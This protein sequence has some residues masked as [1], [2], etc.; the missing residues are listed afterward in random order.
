MSI[1]NHFGITNLCFSKKKNVH[2]FYVYNWVVFMDALNVVCETSFFMETG[3]FSLVDYYISTP[4]ILGKVD[5]FIVASL[6]MWS[7]HAPLHIQVHTFNISD[8]SNTVFPNDV[9]EHTV[10]NRT[11]KWEKD[12]LDHARSALQSC[13]DEL[14]K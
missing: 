10:L 14:Q 1:F 9:H 2:F 6:T 3:G 8:I 7:D 12:R 11:F 5:K 4:I 13:M